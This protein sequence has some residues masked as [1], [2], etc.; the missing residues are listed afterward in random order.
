MGSVTRRQLGV[1]AAGTLALS[2]LPRRLRAEGAKLKVGLLSLEGFPGFALIEGAG[3]RFVSIVHVNGGI[4]AR[5]PG[6]SAL[7]ARTSKV[8][9]PSARGGVVA[10]LGQGWK[11]AGSALSSRH[12][13][14]A[15]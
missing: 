3:G 8:W 9:T 1:A 11:A 2:A 12:S 10:G 13:N 6:P 14:V 4:G 5:S 7:T 15:V